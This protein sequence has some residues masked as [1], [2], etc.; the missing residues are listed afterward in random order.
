M[1][2]ILLCLIA[3]A[4]PGFAAEP[5]LRLTTPDF[6]LYTSAGEKKGRDTILHFEQ[7]RAFFLKASPVKRTAD[8]PV[9]LVQFGTQKEFDPFKIN[10]SSIAYFTGTP[11]RDYIVMNDAA[12]ADGGVAIHEYFHLV[13]RHSGLRIPVWLNEGWADVYSTLRPL[14][15]ETAIGD[16]L[17]GRVKDLERN[18][19]LSF[20][21]L[22]S[23]D[24]NSP[25]YN[26]AG[27]AGVF[28]AESWAL[29]HML[30]FAPEYE[31]NFGKFVMALHQGRSAAEACQI[32]W[33]RTAAE[34]FADLHKYLD[35]KKI[36]GKAYEIKL[37]KAQVEPLVS[38][39]TDFDGK[40]MLGDLLAASNRR[41]DAKKVYDKL[42]SEQPG[43][44]DVAMSMGYLAMENR[45]AAGMLKFFGKAFDAGETDAQM[46][47]RLA[48]SMR[49]TRQPVAKIVPVLQRALKS[50]PDY[51]DAAIELGL[52]Q[53]DG[54]DFAGGIATLMA[55]PAV[56]PDRAA[57][58][59][60]ALGFAHTE[61]GYLAEA[62]GNLET[63]RKWAKTTQET[64]VAERLG[65]FIEARGRDDADVHPGEKLRRIRGAARNVD[66]SA[67]RK[68]LQI[69]AGNELKTF[70]LPDSR[71]VDVLRSHG[72]SFDFACGPLNGFQ[73]GVEYAP[74]RS[75][76]ETSAGI[77]RTL[78]F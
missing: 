27:R 1:N 54:R 62:R 42:D 10:D 20:N 76:I 48:A 33:G 4:L 65:G 34:V 15:N 14:G 7:V 50:R 11:S 13:V 58:V 61:T 36:Y 12:N 16:M 70:D 44:A 8:F 39:V 25:E 67:D 30:Y 40:L 69:Q 60:C 72:V 45:D 64:G 22:T 71:A 17:A 3:A 78:E 19:W 21:E 31:A 51:T 73:V 24:R 68:R 2:R 23:V 38:A 29:T 53:V 49:E 74:P 37:D 57:T 41:G 35:R 55:I 43:R 28:Y 77:V 32:A 56:T 75:A 66:C 63:C 9:R 26:E 52:V 6:E 47:L 46:C 18:A 5:W 59:Y